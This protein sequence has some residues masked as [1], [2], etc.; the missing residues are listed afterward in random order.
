MKPFFFNSI[1]KQHIYFSVLQ[2]VLILCWLVMLRKT[3]GYYLPYMIAGSSGVI[4]TFFNSVKKGNFK[5]NKSNRYI[6]AF[7]S[8][9]S[10][11]IV[12]ANYGLFTD[13]NDAVT[14]VVRFIPYKATV[15]IMLIGGFCA[16][17]NL[18]KFLNDKLENFYW[19]RQEKYKLHPFCI[20]F[21]SLVLVSGMNTVVMFLCY[22]PGNISP[23]SMEIIKQ[24]LDG[25]YSNHH[26]YYYT[27][28]VEIFLTWGMNRF[29]D[30]NSAIASFSMFQIVFM[31]ACISFV[32]VTLYQMKVSWKLILSCMIWY[33]AMPFHI[34]Y[35]FTMW[36]DVMF[37]GAAA[38][39]IVSLFRIWKKIG[40]AEHINYFLMTVGS[41]G[42]CLF[43]SNGW[44]SFLLAFLCFILLF[45]ESTE[46]K[47]MRM[48]F[49]GTLVV[50]FILK[51]PVLN[52]LEVRQPD[53]LESLSIPAQQVARIVSDC[54]DVRE[55]QMELL[56]RVVDADQISDVYIPYLS[57]P[58]KKLV[59]ETGNLQYL[60]DHKAIYIKLYLEMNLAH[61]DK[62]VEA[63]IDQTK[64]YWNGG[65]YYW[66]WVDQ[67]VENDIGAE[68]MVRAPGMKRVVDK[69]LWL[70]VE[71]PLLQIFLCIGFHVWI[72]LILAFLCI[73][74]R[75]K[76]GLFLIIPLIS[77]VV[78]L[79]VATPVFSEFRYIYAVFCCIPFLVT[80][81]FYK[82]DDQN[83]DTGSIQI[84][85]DEEQ[86]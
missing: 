76:E 17:G 71:N 23:D 31:A 78:S 25:S 39:F 46:K 29:H 18:L 3:E 27:K 30:I 41:V 66:W 44:F 6:A 12:S 37:G 59:R 21:I 84:I 63:W 77:I 2:M 38:V 13:T 53:V 81:V 61:M 20:F 54:D 35:S 85:T 65:Y 48:L 52:A 4:S 28:V 68:R 42:M 64:G 83:Q 74:R 15:L 7:S 82:K 79:L 32:I 73:V 80:A 67:V 51:N 22:Y 75:D 45:E 72:V 1:K 47:K 70:Y 10:V 14:S 58:I 43:R 62:S 50:T 33:M 55:D 60:T 40:K 19:Q 9:F 86:L 5:K 24:I 56:K 34:M 36:K 11:M 8:L 69:Y 49:L 57:D 26:P 16:F